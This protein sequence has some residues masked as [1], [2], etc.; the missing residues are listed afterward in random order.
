MGEELTP[1]RRTEHAI[2]NSEVRWVNCHRQHATSEQNDR[3]RWV[4]SEKAAPQVGPQVKMISASH[5]K[6]DA[7]AAQDEKQT[8]TEPPERH[9]KRLDCVVELRPNHLP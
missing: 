3:V 9:D 7:K 5:G 1:C 8:N 6:M 2:W 4:D